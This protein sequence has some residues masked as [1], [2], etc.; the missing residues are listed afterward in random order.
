MV[1]EGGGGIEA[2]SF[3]IVVDDVGLGV[4]PLEVGD[5]KQKVGSLKLIADG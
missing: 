5:L 2:E 3:V 1:G 4:W